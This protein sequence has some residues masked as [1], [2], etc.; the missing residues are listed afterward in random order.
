MADEDD[1]M[2]D[3]WL[4]H[5]KQF[6]RQQRTADRSKKKRKEPTPPPPPVSVLE[7]QQREQGLAKPIGQDN[8]GSS[9]SH[10]TFISPTTTM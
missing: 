1:F 7:K 6:D 3:A 4:E 8:I 5:A 2:S 10:F 9:Q